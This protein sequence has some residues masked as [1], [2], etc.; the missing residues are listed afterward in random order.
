MAFVHTESGICGKTELDLFSVPPTQTEIEDGQWVVHHP[1]ST[2]TENG[3]IEFHIPGAGNDYIDL[4]NTRLLVKAK[5]TKSTGGDIVDTDKV[6]P[7]NLLLHSLFTQVDVS[8]NEKLVTP[9][10]NTYP[11]RAYIETL[12]SHGGDAQQSRLTTSMWY[13][14]KAG[15][16]DAAA[17]M[18]S[19][20][21][22]NT[23]RSIMSDSKSVEMIGRLHIDFCHQPRYLINGIDVKLRLVR[24]K[25]EFALMASGDDMFKI[26]ITEACLYVRKCQ[27][28]PSV[29]LHHAKALETTNVKYPI[30]RVETKVFSIPSGNLSATQENLFLGQLPRR[31]IIG[32]VD[33]D[34]YNGSY[35][36]SPFNFKHNNLN[37][38]ALFIDGKQVPAKPLQP[39]FD[40]T[41]GTQYTRCYQTLFEGTGRVDDDAGNT[42]P[43]SDYPLGFTLYAFDLTPDLCDGDHLNL[44]K[45]G[46]LRLEMQFST[47]LTA[48]SNVVVYA[49]FENLVEVDK[50][51]NIIFDY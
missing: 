18:A 29:L 36:K 26:Q 10:T 12:L 20:P 45:K 9:S 22:L 30:Q 27:L 31:I 11:Y 43:L 13:K 39:N 34:A 28:S 15:Y 2:L 51:R 37:F 41:T 21:G 7:I 35:V 8:L 25:N 32:M 42:I 19:N 47:A 44:R 23:R 16:H 38:L 49:E 4:A 3:P 33:T 24:S 50:S 5:I 48:A 1:L 6:A 40:V 46:N 17:N 14:D